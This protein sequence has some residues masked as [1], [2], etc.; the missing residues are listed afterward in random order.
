MNAQ[1]L[2]IAI[3]TRA[4]KRG[5]VISGINDSVSVQLC[6]YADCW[7]VIFHQHEWFVLGSFDT[8]AEAEEFCSNGRKNWRAIDRMLD[9]IEREAE[10]FEKA[11]LEESIADYTEALGPEADHSDVE[12]FLTARQLLDHLTRGI[13]PQV[14]ELTSL[15]PTAQTVMYHPSHSHRPKHEEIFFDPDPLEYRF[16]GKRRCL[17]PFGPSHA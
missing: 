13:L 11:C 3:L 7:A 14:T 2:L 1:K 16:T 6:Q 8:K 15:I 5:L 9:L 17:G 10:A 4:N 12:T